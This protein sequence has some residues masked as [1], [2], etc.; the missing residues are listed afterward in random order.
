[1]VSMRDLGGGGQLLL[2]MQRI[3]GQLLLQWSGEF[4]LLPQAHEV[5]TGGQLLP[6]PHPI[7]HT[8]SHTILL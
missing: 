5:G 7:S 6:Q 4:K 3:L 8:F 2:N 1:M